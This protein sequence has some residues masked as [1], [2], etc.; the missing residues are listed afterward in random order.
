MNSG[1]LY[2]QGIIQIQRKRELIDS[3]QE[4]K[5]RNELQDVFDYPEIN[6]KSRVIVGERDPMQF[7]E[8]STKWLEDRNKKVEETRKQEIDRERSFSPIKRSDTPKGY[9]SII[10]DWEN[11]V[12]TYYEKKN[13][14]NDFFTHTPEINSNSRAML[15]VYSESVEERL[16]KLNHE[17]SEKI[18]ELRKK[19]EIESI[20]SFKPQVNP[21]SKLRPEDINSYLYQEGLQMMEKKKRAAEI[22]NNNNFSFKPTI[23]ENSKVIASNRKAK[24]PQI[25]EEIAEPVASRVLKP[26]EFENFLQRNYKISPKPVSRI[27]EK[28]EPSKR[29]VKTPVPSNFYE[30]EMKRISEKE[31]KRV[32]ILKAKEMTELDGCTFR[33]KLTPRIRTPPPTA[34]QDKENSKRL[35][36]GKGV[37][38]NVEYI[39][40]SDKNLKV[41]QLKANF[42]VDR[43]LFELVEEIEKKL[44]DVSGT[45][46]VA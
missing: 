16:T 22:C 39:R 46:L 2:E 42:F 37:K 36:Y 3:V 31:Q 13:K 27:E 45:L 6:Y 26:E 1:R 17:R 21:S 25:D 19:I 12:N 28:S 9:Q 30:K 15:P 35:K 20:P 40:Y 5:V 33:P 11:R 44:E 32:E 43:K 41:L 29:Q 24:S 34:S 38:T 8:Y 18:Q 10:T 14:N 4:E 23:N 7:H